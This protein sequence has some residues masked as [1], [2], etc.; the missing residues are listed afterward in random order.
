M[1]QGEA[2]F[3]GSFWCCALMTSPEAGQWDA[4]GEQ[5][6]GKF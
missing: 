2:V 1:G 4:S 6:Q 5:R 3:P